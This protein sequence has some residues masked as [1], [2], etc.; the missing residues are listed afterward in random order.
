MAPVTRF[1]ATT[2]RAIP[3]LRRL[4]A[5]PGT[6]LTRASTA[7]NAANLAPAF[8]GEM[9][10]RYAGT[11]LGRQELE[12]EIVADRVDA[13]WRREWFA[14]QRV[15]NAPDLMRIVVAVDPPATSGALADACGIVAA[16]RGRDGRG[17][18]L[19][20]VTVKGFEPLGWARTAVEAYRRFAADCLVVETNQGGEMVETVIRQVA[21]GLPVRR[22]RATRGKWVRA[23]PV[24]ALYG[25]GRI[26]HVGPL[27]DLEEQL[28]DFGPGGLPGGKSPDR[29]DA[30]VWALTE[31]MLEDGAV[32]AIRTL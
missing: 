27:P 32:P 22:V 17:Y 2:P 23:E 8:I 5:E 11:L 25:E 31:L 26:S 3:L 24:A 30:L 10:R 29:L 16:G 7:S 4:L 28:C 20:D 19:A 13:L 14:Q 15:E 9:Q 18:V 12:G 21:P 6:I 1:R